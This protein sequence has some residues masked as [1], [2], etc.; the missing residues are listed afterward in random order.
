MARPSR[1]SVGRRGFLK[2]AAAGAA[3]IVSAPAVADATQQNQ[4]GDP[5]PARA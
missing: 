4:Q 3:A 2:K 1:G 5:A